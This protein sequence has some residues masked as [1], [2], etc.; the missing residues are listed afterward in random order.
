MVYLFLWLIYGCY[1]VQKMGDVVQMCG[2]D[3][4]NSKRASLE[5]LLLR[6]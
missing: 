6:M 4:E 2:Y 1:N 5:R 3:E